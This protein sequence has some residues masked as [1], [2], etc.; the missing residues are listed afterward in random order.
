MNITKLSKETGISRGV[1]HKYLKA[2]VPAEDVGRVKLTSSE[3]LIRGMKRSGAIERLSLDL[4]T[5]IIY[6]DDER[7]DERLVNYYLHE[8][9]SGLNIKVTYGTLLAAL[10]KYGGGKV[11][12]STRDALLKLKWDGVKRLNNGG[13][14]EFFGDGEYDA[15]SL[16]R[17]IA[18]R[19]LSPGC[20]IKNVYSIHGEFASAIRSI[21]AA[22]GGGWYARTRDWKEVM[23]Y[24]S[25][26][27]FVHVYAKDFSR[28]SRDN[29]QKNI[30]FLKS[31]EAGTCDKFK[32]KVSHV[33]V[34]LGED[35]IDLS[36]FGVVELFTHKH[37]YDDNLAA[38][39]LAEAVSEVENA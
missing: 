20:D 19:V 10:L 25:R 26:G 31:T 6:L 30:D 36:G 3:L 38:Q 21:N 34:I 16:F 33:P 39:L 14:H 1:V 8:S 32:F 29:I 4:D 11:F 7:L 13:G 28:M 5:H 15:S 37:Q 22:V 24:L 12:R 18:S 35:S 23:N 27:D 17:D 9:I 2:G